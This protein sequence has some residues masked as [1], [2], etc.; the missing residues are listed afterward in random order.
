MSMFCVLIVNFSLNDGE[1][2]KYVVGSVVEFHHNIMI[3]LIPGQ[4]TA[5]SCNQLHK[6]IE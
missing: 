3:I 6:H 1:Y 5:G 4:S 2:I